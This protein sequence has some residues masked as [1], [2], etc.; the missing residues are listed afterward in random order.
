MDAD[1][2]VRALG[3]APHPEGGFF[4][5]TYRA[6]GMV[7]TPRGP[8]AA[9]TAIY[10]LVTAG[11]FSALHRIASDEAWHFH[12]G[13]PLRVVVLG[14]DGARTDVVL[15]LDLER[16]QRPQAVVSAGAWFGARIEGEGDWSLVG[17][18]VA[19]GFD[20]ADFE[21]GAREAL[22][23]RFPEHADIVRALTR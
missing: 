13:A 11:S 8:R 3:L 14:E 6:S 17:C 4:R 21:L 7:A 10:F 20:F 18:T 15:G 9:S 22:L 2:I 23:A 19:P 5:E 1:S 16:G 12:A